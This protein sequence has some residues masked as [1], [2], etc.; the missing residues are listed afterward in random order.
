MRGL[1]VLRHQVLG[2]IAFGV[3]EILPLRQIGSGD[4]GVFNH[5]RVVELHAE[6]AGGLVR[7]PRQDLEGFV[8]VSPNLGDEFIMSK[9]LAA[10][11]AIVDVDLCFLEG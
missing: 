9:P 3:D 10:E 4:V 8:A 5:D 11:Q 2:E 7:A 6:S 1:G